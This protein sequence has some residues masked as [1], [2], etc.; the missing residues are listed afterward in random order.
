MT[1]DV[2]ICSAAAAEVVAA[3]IGNRAL[4]HAPD[5]VIA[6]TVPPVVD[7]PLMVDGELM[8]I[9]RDSLDVALRF[10]WYAV[11]REFNRL[12]Y[13][14]L[15]ARG[16][17]STRVHAEICLLSKHRHSLGLSERQVRGAIGVEH[18]IFGRHGRW[19]RAGLPGDDPTSSVEAGLLDCGSG[20]PE[21][22]ASKRIKLRVLS[23]TEFPLILE[24][25]VESCTGKPDQ[26]D[27][28]TEMKWILSRV[29]E[30]PDF[31]T[32]PSQIA[33]KTWLLL[34]DPAGVDP[35]MRDLL[36]MTWSKRMAPGDAKGGS[37]AVFAADRVSGLDGMDDDASLEKR[38]FGEA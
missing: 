21:T 30:W 6:I 19:L 8:P 11:S 25:A 9:S 27:F 33:I 3:R 20:H 35:L 17:D 37:S 13:D 38:L 15:K 2:L 36:K 18:G 4:D 10:V 23:A 1:S 22:V 29:R 14:A 26:V 34:N 7:T 16:F 31:T 28:Q 12:F 5:A 32:A 24:D